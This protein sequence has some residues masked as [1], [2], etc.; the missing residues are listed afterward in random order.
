MSD[1]YKK[2]DIPALDDQ[3]AKQMLENIFEACDMESNKIPLEVLTSYSNYRRERFALQ[4]L[5]L[6]V[7]MVLFFLLPVLFIAPKISIQEL[8]TA[9]SADPVYELRVTSAFPPVSR[10]TATIDGR[11]IP[12]YETGTRQYSI[13]PTMNGTMTITVVLSN[14]Q[15]AVETVEVSGID[16]TSP[17]LV[18]NELKDGQLL[19]YLQDEEGGSGIDY[20]HIYAADG[21]GEQLRP[22][23]WDEE[24][25]CVV[26]DYPAASLNIFVPDYAGNTLQL[27]LT[28]KQ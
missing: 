17:V 13:E 11:N 1:E 26:F 12:V 6:V 9:V 7:I 15:Y 21:T 10:V 23:S 14:H 2:T 22:V 19:L 5:V 3:I 8:P 4:R 24:T 25:G 20:E 27:I 18:S 28:L 16:R